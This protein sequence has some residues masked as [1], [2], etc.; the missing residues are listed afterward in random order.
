MLELV[1][2]HIKLCERELGKLKAAAP[3][4]VT[5]QQRLWDMLLLVAM[6]VW[7]YFA[8]GMGPSDEPLTLG[9][10]AGSLVLLPL[11]YGGV[12]KAV[13]VMLLLAAAWRVVSVRVQ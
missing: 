5:T 11:G 3:R 10:V 7:V 9:G 6:G 13:A 1:S 2:S 12:E 4:I 8:M